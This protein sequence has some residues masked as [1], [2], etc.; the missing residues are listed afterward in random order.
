MNE[1]LLQ[2]LKNSF[3]YPQYLNLLEELVKNGNTTGEPT[4]DRINFTALNFKRIQRLNKRIR[5]PEEQKTIFKNIETKQTWLVLLESWCADGA[6]TI[7]VLNKI[8]E[9]SDN[10][11]LKI[12]LRDENPE[13]MDNFLTNGTRSIP[14]LIILDEDFQVMATWGPRSV[15]ATKMVADYKEEFGKID[16][17]F[18][19]RLQV[20]YNKDHGLSIINELS[21]IVQKLEKNSFTSV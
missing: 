2:S 1:L 13:I 10:I 5:L 6:Q 9:T 11:S 3:S 20:W 14:K 18:K 15:P 19:A 21:D 16:A 17:T 12:I 4:E 7:P 8:A